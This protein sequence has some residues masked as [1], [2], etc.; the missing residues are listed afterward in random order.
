MRSAQ[1]GGLLF[2]AELRPHR[3]L[4]PQGFVWLMTGLCLVSFIAGLAFYLAGAWPVIGF[5]GADVL[6]I[7]AA[8]R[9]NYRRAHMRET[10]QLTP[11]QLRVRRINHWGEI[12][13]WDFQTYWLQ[14]LLEETP[15]GDNQLSL[16]SHG[17]SLTIGSF[18]PPRE[19]AE[20]AAALRQALAR[21]RQLAPD[22]DP[23]LAPQA[24]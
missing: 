11:G 7:Y 13:T 4:S 10:L 2:D 17:R 1:E 18:L 22:P 3:S 14:V 6:L 19:R 12:Q 9:I 23:N 5:M 20:V 21:S 15:D 24:G 8:F 16:R